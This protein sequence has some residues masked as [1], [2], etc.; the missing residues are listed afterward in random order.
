MINAKM[1]AWHWQD[2]KNVQ[3][4]RTW[5]FIYIYIHEYVVFSEVI[6]FYCFIMLR[7]DM[8]GT[9]HRSFA[10]IRTLSYKKGFFLSPDVWKALFWNNSNILARDVTRVAAIWKHAERY[11]WRW[12]TIKFHL[13]ESLEIDGESFNNAESREKVA[14]NQV[15]ITKA[16]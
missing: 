2:S 14:K 11:G 10:Y 9:I 3:L 1:P 5:I 16:Q 15:E 12:S 13:F 7:Y 4:T 6:L 8:K